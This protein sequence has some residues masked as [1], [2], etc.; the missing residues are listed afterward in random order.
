LNPKVGLAE[1]PCNTDFSWFGMKKY[2]R[3]LFVFRRDLRL[4]DNTALSAALQSCKQVYVAF[5]LDARQLKPHAYRSHNGLRFMCESLHELAEELR[6][7]GSQLFW[8]EG[9]AEREIPAFMNAH[10]IEALFVNKDYTP[11]S[12]ER[13]KKISQAVEALGKV[14]HSFSDLLL[15]EPSQFAKPDG[16]PYTVFTPF[17][18]RA[19]TQEVRTLSPN[20]FDG[21]ERGEGLVPGNMQDSAFNLESLL[22]QNLAANPRQRGGRAAALKLIAE[23]STKSNYKEER[24]I[25][26]I[27]GTTTLSAHHKFGTCSIREVYWAARELYG[28]DSTLVRE[29]YWRDFFT[30]IAWHFPKVF[31]GAFQQQYDAIQW[32]ENESAFKRF[33]E[34]ETGFPIVDAGIRELLTTGYMHNRVRMIVASFLTKDLH[35]SW[36]WGEQFF[37]KH[38]IDF[39]PSVN[40]GSWQWAAST[41]CDAQ[42]YFRIF[43]PWLQQERFDPDCVYIKRYV[44]E[45][46]TLS[47]KQIHQLGEEG[48]SRPAGYPAAICEHS[49]EKDRAL[50]MF[51][52]IAKK[53]M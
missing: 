44:P 30:H 22:P 9:Q 1:F 17:Y 26:S 37:A 20:P 2:S 15:V 45:L 18:K 4:I 48:A 6:A 52:A 5:V 7:R 29:L 51:E 40:N 41:G 47:P 35:I 28:A 11:F 53:Q 25:P 23:L 43:N 39:D 49:F 34:G 14:F 36:R 46:K 31:S 21:L 12:R 16:K 42:P 24:D 19:L 13:D 50:E 33:C 3:G 8:L 38:L 27:K 32:S 10:Q